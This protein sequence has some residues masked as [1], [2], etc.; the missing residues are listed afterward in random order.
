MQHR[1]FQVWILI[2]SHMDS[3]VSATQNDH[4]PQDP[5][6]NFD[7][8][9]NFN[10][11]EFHQLTCTVPDTV[12]FSCITWCSM[13]TP[14]WDGSHLKRGY[15]TAL[16]ANFAMLAGPTSVV[17]SITRACSG[18]TIETKGDIIVA[19]SNAERSACWI[20]VYLPR[21]ILGGVVWSGRMENWTKS[22]IGRNWETMDQ[23]K[24]KKGK[25]FS[26]VSAVGV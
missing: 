26:S 3:T 20:Y 17:P 9:I 18:S 25:L 5:H 19:Y 24:G 2:Y 23:R 8:W 14:R 16:D 7:A 10:L 15:S 21:T 4:L 13:S 22:G 12:V 6:I 11:S 1:G